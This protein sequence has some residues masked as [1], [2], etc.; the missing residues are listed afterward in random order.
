MDYMG[1]TPP[2][3]TEFGLRDKMRC[4]TRRVRLRGAVVDTTPEPTTFFFLVLVLSTTTFP[5][6]ATD[7]HSR[8]ESGQVI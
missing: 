6:S 8:V 2:E 7:L 4:K 3:Q 5:I 1:I